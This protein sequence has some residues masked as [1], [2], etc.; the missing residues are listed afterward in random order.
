MPDEPRAAGEYP[1]G[2]LG[3]HFP[4]ATPVCFRSRGNGDALCML[5]V[6]VDD[7]KPSVE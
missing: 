5:T 2:F 3:W 1:R 6:K 4:Q 7:E